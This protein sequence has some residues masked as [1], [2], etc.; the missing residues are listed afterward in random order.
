M[1]SLL[2]QLKSSG[3]NIYAIGASTKGNV[4]LQ[5][6]GI[7]HSLINAIGEVNDEKFGRYSPGTNI[8]IINEI[9][10]LAQ[11][12]DYLLVLPWH[13]KPYFLSES[14]FKGSKFIFPLPKIEIISV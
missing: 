3:K 6:F 7:D 8:P 4:L 2:Q 11:K 14:R 9:E 5:F 12:P 1:I 13:F 10:V